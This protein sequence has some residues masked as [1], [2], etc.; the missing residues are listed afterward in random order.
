M[1]F[2]PD[3]DR[4]W[5]DTLARLATVPLNSRSEAI[6]E[7]VPF[8]Q[9]RID[10]QSLDGVPIR[11]R[12]SK[13][14]GGAAERRLPAIVT[15]PGY[16]GWE[17]GVMPGECQRGYIILQVFPCSQGESAELWSID[18]PEKLTWKIEQPEGY[19]YQGAYCDVIRGIDYLLTRDDVDPARIAMM[20]TSQGGG[21]AL[22]VSALDPRIKATVAHV[23]FLCDMR[24]CIDIDG[25]LAQRLLQPIA[26]SYPAHLETLDY[27]DPVCLASRLHAPT[28]L[29]AGGQD[30]VC[31]A[32]SIQAVFER[33]SDI[34]ALMYYPE[35]IHTSSQDFYEMSWQWMVRYL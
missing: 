8:L 12:L 31:P 10:Y 13:P 17:H 16:G 18:G 35:L 19:Y 20:G 1:L 22:A 5:R 25:S 33:L 30:V 14:I 4:F 27:F 29:S 34:K 26:E 23:P 6:A 7:P 2:L 9:E 32:A 15:A 3:I 28:L 11:A 21:I 24:G